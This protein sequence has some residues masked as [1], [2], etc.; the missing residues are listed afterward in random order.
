MKLT[1]EQL[2]TIKD[3]LLEQQ[4][5]NCSEGDPT[6]HEAVGFECGVIFMSKVLDLNWKEIVRSSKQSV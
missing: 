2:E 6:F 3:K 1:K 4:N 5:I